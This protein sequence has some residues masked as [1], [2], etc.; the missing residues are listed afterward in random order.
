LRLIRHLDEGHAIT[1]GTDGLL[2]AVQQL[3]LLTATRRVIESTV[4][5]VPDKDAASFLL[6]RSLEYVDG[7]RRSLWYESIVHEPQVALR[8]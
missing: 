8:S 5:S 3:E 4:A 7:F 1:D 6:A 2:R